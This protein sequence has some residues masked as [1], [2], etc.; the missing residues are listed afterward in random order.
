MTAQRLLRALAEVMDSHDWEALPGL[1][2]EEFSCHYV[3]TGETF[4]AHAWVRLNA[5]YPGFQ[6][7]ILEDCVADGDRAVGRFHVTALGQD[8]LQHFE[9]ASFITVRD[10]LLVSMTEVWTDVNE[11]APA[12]TRPE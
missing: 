10:E 4:S 11:V 7:F 5:E 3:H 8:G 2:H 6:R 12:G 1:L 9:V